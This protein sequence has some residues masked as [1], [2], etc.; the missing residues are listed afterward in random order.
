MQK[1][2][3][4]LQNNTSSQA[5]VQMH[6]QYQQVLASFLQNVHIFIIQKLHQKVTGF[7]WNQFWSMLA[8][9]KHLID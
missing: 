8:T 2:W 9:R 7:T 1:N 4:L 6:Q 5:L 3:H